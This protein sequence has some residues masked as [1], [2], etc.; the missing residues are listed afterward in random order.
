MGIF[1]G[2][3]KDWDEIGLRS[4]RFDFLFVLMFFFSFFFFFLLL[5]FVLGFVPSPLLFCFG[6]QVCWH[7][8]HGLLTRSL[9]VPHRQS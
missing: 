5:F 6:C 2:Q 1:G 3:K 8:T 9:I 7:H 4:S